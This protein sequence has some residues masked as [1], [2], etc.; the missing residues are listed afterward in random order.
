MQYPLIIKDMQIT[1]D[2]RI[3]H[4]QLIVV[5]DVPKRFDRLVGHLHDIVRQ[6]LRRESPVGKPDAFNISI[7][8]QRD[9]PSVRLH[10]FFRQGSSL[11]KDRD[12]GERIE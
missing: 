4:L 12:R 2:H 7:N 11:E 6:V 5:D 3:D 1:R 8:I 9:D 10:V